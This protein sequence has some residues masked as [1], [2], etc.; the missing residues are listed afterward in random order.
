MCVCVCVYVCWGNGEV[1]MGDR[2]CM[3]WYDRDGFGYQVSR[4][5]GEMGLDFGNEDR[6]YISVK[7]HL[8]CD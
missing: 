6:V 7:V 8:I 5:E 3:L 2:E 1:M 4:N